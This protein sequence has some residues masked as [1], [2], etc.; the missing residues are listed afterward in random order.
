MSRLP[1]PARGSL[2]TALLLAL[3]LLAA[4]ALRYAGP[5]WDDGHSQHPDERFM[6]MVTQ[7]LQAPRGTLDFFDT[8]RSTM[9]P[10]NRGFDGFAY[11]MLPLFIVK[12]LSLLLKIDGFNELEWLGRA[13][14]ATFDLGTVLLVFLLGRQLYGRAVG[15][16]A[17]ALAAFTVL[18]I[19][20]AHF[21][22][23]DSFLA[24]FTAL[25]LLFAYRTWRNGR[26]RDAAVL[27]LGLGCAGATKLSGLLLLPIAVTACLLSTTEPGKGRR[28]WPTLLA[29][30]L[31]AAGV[32]FR[33]GEPY[34]F[35]GPTPLG[36]WPNLQR[37]EDLARWVKISAGEIEVPYMVQW[38]RTQPYVY[39]IRVLVQWGMGVP[40]GLA[41]LGGL[42]LAA[43]ELPKWRRFRWHLLL[44]AWS[45]LCLLYFG[46]QFAKFLRYLVPVYP[47]L[48]VLAAYAVARLW[49]RSGQL[50][51]AGTPV[52][53]LLAGLAIVAGLGY[54][55][56]Y[57]VAFTTLYLR[58]HSR[59][60]ASEWI[61]ANVPPGATLAVEHWD[62][63]LPFPLSGGRDPN[64][65]RYVTLNLYDDESPHKA[66]QLA[67]ALDQADYL[68]LASYRL[69]GSIPRLPER[70]PL[71]TAY[72]RMLFDGELGF[73]QAALIQQRPALFGLSVDDTSAPEDL[74]VYEHPTVTIFRKTPQYSP[75]RVRALFQAIPIE[76]A[77]QVAPLHAGRGTL[78]LD[79]TQRQ[80][81]E[82]SGTW[83]ELY[84]RTSLPNQLPLLFWLLL[85]E[86]IGLVAF[87][88]VWR[89][90]P[91][92]PDRGWTAAKT[93][94]LVAV[95]YLAWLLQSLGLAS[96]GRTT[97]LLGLALIAVGSLLVL[98]HERA[99]LG[100]WLRR[101]RE[102]LV[103]GEAVFL[104]GF[105]LLLAIRL[106]NPDLWHPSFGGE[107]P[108]DFAY[109]N[110][111]LKSAV[112]PPYDP[113]FA[114]GY[115]NYYY[116]GFVLAAVPTRLLGIVPAVAYNLVIPTFFAL[117]CSG[118]FGFVSAVVLARPRLAGPEGR[119]L[120]LV[121]ALAG[122]L[123]V[124]VL[125]DLDGLLQIV[126]GLAKLAPP[127]VGTTLPLLGTLLKVLAALPVW[128]GGGHLPP[129]D[130]WRPTRV[131]GPEE[132]GP[133]TEFPF[134]TFLYGDLHAHLLALPVTV[135][136]LLVALNAARTRPSIRAL[137]LD[138]AL[139]WR[140]L[141]LAPSVLLLALL[142]GTLRATNTWDFPI[143]CGLG[144][145]GLALAVRPRTWRRW[146]PAL[147]AA[148]A[149]AAAVYLGATVLF[150]PYL[151]HYQLFYTGFDP[152][153][154]TTALGQFLT[155]HGLNLFL[156]LSA[157]LLEIALF[158]RARR[159]WATGPGAPRAAYG[160]AVPAPPLV[161]SDRPEV[162][163][164]A[165]LTM[166]AAGFYL[167][168]SRSA[169][170]LLLASAA[171]PVLLVRRRFS[172]T[173][174]LLLG[175]FAAAL[176]ALLLPE[177]VRLQGDVGRMNTV[178]KFHLQAW[179]LLALSGA[180][181]LVYVLRKR[182]LLPATLASWQDLWAATLLVLV[183]GAAL[184]PLLGTPA[185]TGLRFPT[186]PPQLTLDGMA[187]LCCATYV[188]KGRDLALPDDG[189]A[190]T[191]LQDHV[192]GTPVIAEGN[193]GLYTWGSRVSISTGLPTIIGWDWHQKQQRWGYQ[194]MIERR[195]ADVRQLYE[196]SSMQSAW[197][198]L[199]RYNVEYIYVGGLERAYYPAEGL[200][201]FG[202]AVGHGL[203][204]V[205]Q[206]GQ[207]TIYHVDEIPNG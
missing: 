191:W 172:T 60:L 153:P 54:T 52:L 34:L 39:P 98:R 108:M 124:G 117:L 106:L 72:Y 200:R 66:E 53:R 62:D 201:K 161:L 105:G 42:A 142:V 93:L 95:A 173:G 126:Q 197:P 22:T 61:Y 205:Y 87:P 114:G 116:Y 73:S 137:E 11:G 166:L 125:G 19:Q 152:S 18:Q 25:T 198:I 58:P 178:F 13:T 165:G 77:V 150:A 175:M 145:L 26:W 1:L 107:K 111:V 146:Q 67:R 136:V 188:D 7:A 44:T 64:R 189:R 174:L 40:L 15:L 176:A 85:L 5:N 139:P 151:S 24:F 65:Y 59:V 159:V 127:S 186:P 109:F 33:V 78:L 80:Q 183:L 32:A 130:F 192:Q 182:R 41:A 207:V 157:L 202:D 49:E 156:V 168:G 38:A 135:A 14:S 164:A 121:A 129:F 180:A 138:H 167:A 118:A 83:S 134:F 86:A 48:A 63:Q 149:L 123:L 6:V 29:V 184:Y 84:D 144:V 43:L 163:A 8:A 100:A 158:F 203:S 141:P 36:I 204:R 71:A 51:L 12:G 82:S 162:A 57:A 187:Y 160:L 91:H 113:W 181:G 27:G 169:A 148:L 90:F 199:K 56:W 147:A 119:A 23:V 195:L 28:E 190:I 96:F 170:L 4:A 196:S 31:V 120:G 10:Y 102:A 206:A 21:Y 128:L 2:A 3:I 69:A 104:A 79:P 16:L 143:Y 132:P 193:A 131:I 37:I 115:I 122:V 47:A 88:L 45:V 50:R 68:I 30:A 94:A 35:L 140:L 133:I 76:D 185:K 20:L 81:I 70:Y 101:S 155:I 171:I 110:A 9:N 89:L 17:A 194:S 179:V 99:A 112:F 74:T 92:L 46:G 177:L 103:W 97:L 154:A 75:E 55:A